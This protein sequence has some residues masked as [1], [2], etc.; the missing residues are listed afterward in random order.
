MEGLSGIDC[1]LRSRVG[2]D[3]E[4]GPVAW[5]S[6]S[7]VRIWLGAEVTDMSRRSRLSTTL[8]PTCR[9]QQMRS[10]AAYGG[11]L[12]RDLQQ[13]HLG[14]EDATAAADEHRP[15]TDILIFSQVISFTAGEE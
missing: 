10:S 6:F 4:R 7:R 1:P 5:N 11:R 13:S 12:R 14:R 3:R 9:P 15:R 2:Y 8:S